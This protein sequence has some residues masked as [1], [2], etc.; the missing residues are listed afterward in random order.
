MNNMTEPKI[1]TNDL[2]D[3]Y[4]Q[5]KGQK[6]KE[7]S[8]KEKAEIILENMEKYLQVDYAFKDFYIKGIV[9]GLNEIEKEEGARR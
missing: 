2:S 5:R 9:N 6:M 7:L 4:N 3:R 1:E 8:K